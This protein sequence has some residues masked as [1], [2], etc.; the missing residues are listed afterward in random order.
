MG[1]NFTHCLWTPRS[2]INWLSTSPGGSI[3][4]SSIALPLFPQTFEPLGL[5]AGSFEIIKKLIYLKVRWGIYLQVT[6]W[7]DFSFQ[8]SSQSTAQG[9]HEHSE[10]FSVGGRKHNL[11]GIM[12]AQRGGNSIIY[13]FI[14]AY[15]WNMYILSNSMHCNSFE[16]WQRLETSC[17]GRYQNVSDSWVWVLE[18]R[19]HI[20]SFVYFQ[21]LKCDHF[22]G[23][24]WK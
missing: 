16:S 15:I 11:A 20:S 17:G 5:K 21:F 8:I 1:G 18:Q 24:I 6:R 22:T 3:Q 12:D 7:L 14:Y 10:M 13:I 19:G 2:S 23:M 4:N 9:T